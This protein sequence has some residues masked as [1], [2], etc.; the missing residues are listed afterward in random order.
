VTQIQGVVL[1]SVERKSIK[2]PEVKLNIT[3]PRITSSALSGEEVGHMVDQAIS[4]SL[5][6][7]LQK[8]ID[9]SVDSQLESSLDSNVCS[10][11]LHVNDE[12]AKNKLNLPNLMLRRL[13]LVFSITILKIATITLIRPRSVVF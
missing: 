10:A 7:R 6:N 13:S 11:M 3:P 2:I 4:A 12:T 1:P 9:G 8:M 5:A